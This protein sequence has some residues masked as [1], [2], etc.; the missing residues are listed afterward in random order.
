MS[1]FKQLR[2][3]LENE[4]LLPEGELT[5]EAEAEAD[6]AMVEAEAVRQEI[7]NNIEAQERA[8]AVVEELE[9]TNEALTNIAA[10]SPDGTIDEATAAMAEAQRRTAAAAVG[11]D[12]EEGAGAEL[13]DQAGLESLVEGTYLSLEEATSKTQKIIDGIWNFIKEIGKKISSAWKRFKEFMGKVFNTTTNQMKDA[14]TFVN[15]T[16]NG[17]LEKAFAAIDKKGLDPVGKPNKFPEVELNKVIDQLGK[18]KL[19]KVADENGKLT[20][21]IKSITVGNTK[22]DIENADTFAIKIAKPANVSNTIGDVVSN[23]EQYNAEL[24]LVS[25]FNNLVERGVAW[26]AEDLYAALAGNIFGGA[27]KDI[28]DASKPR[29]FAMFINRSLAFQRNVESAYMQHAKLVLKY[30]KLIKAEISKQ[31]KQ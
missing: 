7:E 1:Y 20:A 19:K 4:E 16:E 17:K 23:I 29:Q 28:N 15:E 5:P 26:L 11:L 22:F 10:N 12:P 25:K 2:A 14:L 6:V 21:P 9:G 3:S 13:V 31:D 8:E 24:A 18:A 30:V 27:N